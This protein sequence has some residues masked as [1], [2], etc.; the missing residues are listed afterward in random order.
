[1]RPMPSCIESRGLTTGLQAQLVTSITERSAYT[2]KSDHTPAGRI[3]LTRPVDNP[4]R[5]HHQ[6]ASREGPGQLPRVWRHRQGPRG[7]EA[8]YH[9]LDCPHRVLDREQALLPRR[10]PGPRRLHQEHDYRCRLHGRR[11]HCRRRLGRP[12]APDP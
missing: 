1:M 9:H 3:E 10:L 2:S 12:D 7:A 4:L 11:H 5:R 8:W 6:E